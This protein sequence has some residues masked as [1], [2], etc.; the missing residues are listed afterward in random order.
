MDVL[1]ARCG[2]CGKLFCTAHI[3]YGAH[4]CTAF[5]DT[6]AAV[7]PVCQQ[8][9]QQRQGETPDAAVSRHLDN[10]GCHDPPKVTRNNFCSFGG[11]TRNEIVLILCER[12]GNSFCVNHRAP[13][14]HLCP[15]RTPPPS[16]VV[17]GG[18]PVSP[19]KPAAV[20]LALKLADR[21]AENTKAAAVGLAKAKDPLILKV[22]PPEELK[23]APVFMAFSRRA[24]A[25]RCVDACCTQWDLVNNNNVTTDEGAKFNLTNLKMLMQIPA[26]MALEEAGLDQCDAVMLHKGPVLPPNIV[27]E[28]EAVHRDLK[29]PATAAA[30]KRK[31]LSGDCAAS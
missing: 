16:S 4:Q 9:V 28:V 18:R 1:P 23:R 13:D 10:G 26:G 25:G 29:N 8:A 11:C 2:K 20:A 3:A 27:A 31:A 6:T 22:F 24:A 15:R 19:A 5:K 12:C 14:Q 17:A 7:C 21:K 30:I